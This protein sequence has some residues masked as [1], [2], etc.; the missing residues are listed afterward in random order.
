MHDYMTLLP[1]RDKPAEYTNKTIE[2]I[3]YSY[4][5]LDIF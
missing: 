3:I 5:N 2:G 4:S 1:T